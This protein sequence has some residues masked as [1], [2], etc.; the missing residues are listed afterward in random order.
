MRYQHSGGDLVMLWY[1]EATVIYLH[2]SSAFCSKDDDRHSGISAVGELA[3]SKNT[4]ETPMISE[5]IN[6][7]SRASSTLSERYGYS[8]SLI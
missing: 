3:A 6:K 7:E 2:I 4:D 1:V 8:Y 5:D